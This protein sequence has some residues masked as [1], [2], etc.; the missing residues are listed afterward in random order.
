[1][2]GELAAQ[3]RKKIFWYKYE[4]QRR[5]CASQY[6][7]QRNTSEQIEQVYLSWR[8]HGTTTATDQTEI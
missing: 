4:T 6:L 7:R 5:S 8:G 1:M 3:Y 2:M